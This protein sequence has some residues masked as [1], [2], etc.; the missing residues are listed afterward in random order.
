MTGSGPVIS[1][2]EGASGAKF[3][4]E[5]SSFCVRVTRSRRTSLSRLRGR[6]ELLVRGLLG[7][8][9]LHVETERAHL[10]DEH[11]EALRNAGLEGVVAAHD[12]L[13]DLGATRHVVRLD[14]EHFLQSVGSPVSFK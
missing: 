3:F 9:Q 1:G 13:I 11:V 2:C 14:G 4:P 7:A 12:R 10:L 8:G 5:P 6:N